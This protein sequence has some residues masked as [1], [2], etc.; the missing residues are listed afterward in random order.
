MQQSVVNI[1]IDMFFTV[2]ISFH[3]KYKLMENQ[4]LSERLGN[5]KKYQTSCIACV[6]EWEKKTVWSFQLKFY[7]SKKKIKKKINWYHLHNKGT[8]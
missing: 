6:V 7:D 8:Y 2:W 1:Y 4:R 3:I 5:T